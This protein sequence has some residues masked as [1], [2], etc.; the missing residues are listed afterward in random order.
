MERVRVFIRIEQPRPSQALRPTPGQALKQLVRSGGLFIE[1]IENW[2]KKKRPRHFSCRRKVQ[3]PLSSWRRRGTPIAKFP[4]AHAGPT[5]R[6]SVPPAQAR[7]ESGFFFR[8]LA[9]GKWGCINPQIFTLNRL[10]SV[11]ISNKDSLGGLQNPKLRFSPG[12]GA[13]NANYRRAISNSNGGRR[14]RSGEGVGASPAI[15]CNFSL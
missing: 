10:V 13:L 9:G 1:G 4:R 5:Q 6:P 12:L 14:A 8:R 11:E 7:R 2:G 3:S 15:K